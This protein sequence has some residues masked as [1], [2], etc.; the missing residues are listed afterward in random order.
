MHR[1]TILGLGRPWNA[2]FFDAGGVRIRAGMMAYVVATGRAG[3]SVSVLGALAACASQPPSVA[4]GP[5]ISPQQE[6]AEAAKYLAHAKPRYQ[7]PGPPTD[8]WGPYVVEAARR[9]DVPDTWIREVMHVESAGYQFRATGELTTS[10]AGAMGLMQLMPDTY[11]QM[12]G[13]YNLGPRFP[14]GLQCRPAAAAGLSGSQQAPAGRNPALCLDD[15]QSHYRR[16]A[17]RAFAGRA[18]GGKPDPPG[19]SAGSAVC[20]PHQHPGGRTRAQAA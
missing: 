19:Y 6:Q 13:R 15:R 5:T 18:V 4:I 11:D 10:P 12:R 9:F 8:P 7:P 1:A 17:E 2:G 3:L 20:P 14:G 16:V